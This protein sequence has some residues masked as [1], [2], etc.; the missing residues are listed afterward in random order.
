MGHA[1]A[2]HFRDQ[3]ANA[4]TNR[5]T[6]HG[7]CNA[8]QRFSANCHIRAQSS[9]RS[10]PNINIHPQGDERTCYFSIFMA[11][12]TLKSILIRAE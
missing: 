4:H 1:T 11:A 2:T 5:R 6:L 9:H 8:T 10:A 12:R 3:P 7:Q